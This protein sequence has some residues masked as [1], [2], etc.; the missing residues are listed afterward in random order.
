MNYLNFLAELSTH[1][2]KL[3]NLAQS[4]LFWIL[5]EG[6]LTGLDASE[7][8]WDWIR[9]ASQQGFTYATTGLASPDSLSLR[10]QAG[11]LAGCEETTQHLQS[12][13]G[14]FICAIKDDGSGS[15]SDAS[16]AFFPL[17]QDESLRLFG[18][19]AQGDDD[20]EDEVFSQP[21]IQQAVGFVKTIIDVL[22]RTPTPTAALVR[23][24]QHGSEVLSPAINRS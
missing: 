20:D 3:S 9:S 15:G 23:G 18:D 24:L 2:E 11:D 5:G 8:W 10:I 1:V 17:M 19:V 13:V 22:N 21:R 14:C 6:I 12:V 16:R 7:E 4:A